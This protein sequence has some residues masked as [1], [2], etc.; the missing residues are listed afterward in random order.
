M[1]LNKCLVFDVWARFGYFRRH[2]STTTATTHPIIPRSAIEGLIASIVGLQSYEFADKML[3][4][5]ITTGLTS[6]NQGNGSSVSSSQIQKIP[7]SLT[8]THSD[9]WS[10]SVPRYLKEG[11]GALNYIRAPRRVEL[12][13]EPCFRIY[14]A[15]GDEE[16]Y[17]QVLDRVKTHTTSY[18][19]SLGSSNMIANFIYKNEFDVY[20][21]E[22]PD[23]FVGISSIVPF[24]GKQLPSPRLDRG[25]RF[26]IEENIPL[27]ISKDRSASGY[28]SALYATY[29]D[30]QINIKGIPYSEL[31]SQDE[32]I[33]VVFIP[34]T[35][36]Q[37]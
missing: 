4:A 13:C 2:Y 12:L 5:L 36:S 23:D 18:T 29:P 16:L 14:F 11:R 6:W 26:A 7:M 19:P 33:N 9:F 20:H 8:Y 34:S 32:R 10:K 15:S 35:P 22:A 1:P 31:R 28:Y 30:R 3:N 21:K 25:M 24:F 37:T 27:H 17:N